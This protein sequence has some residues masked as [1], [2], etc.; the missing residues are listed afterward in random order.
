MHSADT[1]GKGVMTHAPGRPEQDCMR[2]HHTARNGVQFKT[3][4]LI[5]SGI[6][7]LKFLDYG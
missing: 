5:I 3:C 1:L 2:L 7:H 4:K 6:F